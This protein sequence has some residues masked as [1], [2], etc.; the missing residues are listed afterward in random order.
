MSKPVVKR[1]KTKSWEME[2]EWVYRAQGALVCAAFILT[3][4]VLLIL[5]A[6]SNTG[7]T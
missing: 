4:E 1:T 6:M 2:S 7:G 3:V 5:W